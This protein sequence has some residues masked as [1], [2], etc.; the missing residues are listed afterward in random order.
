MEAA[1]WLLL[2][3]SWSCVTAAVVFCLIRVLGSANQ[4]DEAP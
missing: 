3:L 2:V 1:G 4:D